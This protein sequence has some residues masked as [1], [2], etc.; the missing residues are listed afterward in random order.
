MT[1]LVIIGAGPAGLTAAIYSSRA[2]KSVTVIEH[3]TIGG[4]ITS[5]PKVENFPS[6]KS[7]SGAELGEKMYEQAEN[8][9]VKFEFDSIKSVKKQGNYFVV[10]GEYSSFEAKSIIIATGAV[11]RKLNIAREEELVGQGVAYCVVCDGEFFAGKDVAVVG[12]GNSAIQAAIYLSNICKSV[13]ILQNLN[14]L[15]AEK[16]LVDE[17]NTKNNIKI[18]LGVEVHKLL[19][20]DVFTGVE[21]KGKEGLIQVDI[22]GLFVSIGQIPQTDMFKGLVDIDKNGYIISDENC[23]TSMAGVFVAGDCRTKRIRQLTTAVSDGTV[24]SIMA[25]SY[26]DSIK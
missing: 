7:I 16:H 13:H 6:Q 4:Q 22:E 21:V 9:G 10:L 1:D 3:A 23:S 19:G 15:T 20:Q 14:F 8:L 18:T 25:C 24:A 26:I 2:G 11:N 12:G 17:L 5:S